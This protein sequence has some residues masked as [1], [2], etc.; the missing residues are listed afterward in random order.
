M[1]SLISYI[2][3]IIWTYSATTAQE[4][5]SALLSKFWIRDNPRKF[6][7]YEKFEDDGHKGKL[8]K[9]NYNN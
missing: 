1:A 8:N 9:F 6:A 2:A 5:I 3:K 4:V 7:L